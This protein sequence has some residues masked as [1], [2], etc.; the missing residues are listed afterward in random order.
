MYTIKIV[1]NSVLNKKYMLLENW[2]KSNIYTLRGRE[3]I[4]FAKAA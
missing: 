4:N 3:A 2:A 1:F